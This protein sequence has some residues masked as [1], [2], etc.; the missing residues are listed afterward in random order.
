V[1]MTMGD[2]KIETRD[3][4]P[5]MIADVNSQVLRNVEIELTDDVLDMIWPDRHHTS[6]PTEEKE[7]LELVADINSALGT[8]IERTRVILSATPINGT[9]KTKIEV[10]S[11]LNMR[12]FLEKSGV[13]SKGSAWVCLCDGY[14]YTAN[15]LNQ[16]VD[17]LNTEW[18]LDR[19][20]VG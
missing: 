19:H 7:A 18:K 15:T 3:G 11:D 4:T 14:M 5:W 6:D 10:K 1:I 9:D 12:I 2:I 17:V 16:L 20:L 8:L 13:I